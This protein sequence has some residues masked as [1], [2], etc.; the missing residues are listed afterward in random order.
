MDGPLEQD[1]LEYWLR[2]LRNDLGNDPPGWLE[3]AAAPVVPDPDESTDRADADRAA[4]S[5]PDDEQ[6]V[7]GHRVD[8][9]SSVGSYG[10]TRSL[11]PTAGGRHRAAD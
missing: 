7:G 8:E 9:A 3:P 4:A 11:P 10:E 5:P 6:R 2:D 1:G